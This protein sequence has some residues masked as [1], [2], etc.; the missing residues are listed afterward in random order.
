M[1][2]TGFLR[3]VMKRKMTLA[4][5]AL[6]L[7]LT[8]CGG[9]GKRQAGEFPENF[10]TIG[11][12]GRVAYVMRNATPDSVARFICLG[13]LGRVEGARIDTMAMATAYAY[14]HYK[15]EDLDAFGVEYDRFVAALSLADRMKIYALAGSEDPQGLGLQLGLEYTQMIRDKNMDVKAVEKELAEFKKACASDPDTYERFLIGFKTALKADNGTDLPA[16]VYEKFIDY[17]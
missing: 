10:N 1:P 13:A 8:A 16:G 4:A 11:D 7:L 15:G 3:L 9:K 17:K 14:E 12:A 6:A 5:P 2:E